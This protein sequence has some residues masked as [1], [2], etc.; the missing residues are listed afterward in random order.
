MYHLSGLTKCYP[1]GREGAVVRAL[2][3]VELYVEE[4]GALVVQGPAGAGKSTLLR[5]LGGLER[6]T[7]GRV[8]LDGTD[9]ATAA[10]SRLARIRAESIGWV[11]GDA[12]PDPGLTVRQSVAGA[13]VPLRLHPAD[14]WELAGEALEDVGM[15][16]QLDLP[17]GG[18]DVG[19]R[20]R[21]A[22][23]RAL[24][25]RPTVLLADEPTAGLTA[26]AREAMTDFFERL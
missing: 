5:I 8:E 26:G 11:S 14:C 16:G 12:L 23:A 7:R 6:P 22:L 2:D 4:G 3:E 9:L 21:V 20:R 15:G 19:A 13:L 24:V 25:K 17:S 10:E 18:L 1:D